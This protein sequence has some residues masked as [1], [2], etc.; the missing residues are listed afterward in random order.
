MSL[1]CCL[2]DGSEFKAFIS[3]STCSISSPDLGV[4]GLGFGASSKQSARLAK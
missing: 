4:T 1:S 2:G 3:A